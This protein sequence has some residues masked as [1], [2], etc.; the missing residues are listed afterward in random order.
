MLGHGASLTKN[1]VRSQGTW[2]CF[3]SLSITWTF[4]WMFAHMP[5]VYTCTCMAATSLSHTVHEPVSFHRPYKIKVYGPGPCYIG[6][7]SVF[8]VSLCVFS[9]WLSVWVCVWSSGGSRVIHFSLST[10]HT[11]TKSSFYLSFF[12]CLQLTWMSGKTAVTLFLIFNM[13]YSQDTEQSRKE[14]EVSLHMGEE[15]AL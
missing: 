13:N 5:F 9:V 1:T 7:G 4:I 6:G 11:P 14:K 12:G 3:S 8:R 15:S 2:F 10:L